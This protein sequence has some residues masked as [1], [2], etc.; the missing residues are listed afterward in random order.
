M[1]A[2]RPFALR[3]C[4]CSRGVTE[5]AVLAVGITTLHIKVKASSAVTQE[6]ERLQL[7]CWVLGSLST[8]PLSLDVS[9]LLKMDAYHCLL[10][11]QILP[12]LTRRLT[13]LTARVYTSALPSVLT[14]TS[15]T[16]LHL[17]ADFGQAA[18]PPPAWQLPGLVSLRL[19]LSK[20]SLD[21]LLGAGTAPHLTT[22]RVDDCSFGGRTLDGL[23]R[24]PSL[25]SLTLK[26]CGLRQLP[27]L[28]N[29]SNL[30]SLDVSSNEDLLD[31]QPALQG[32]RALVTLSAEWVPL[33]DAFLASVTAVPTCRRVEVTYTTPLSYFFV[34]HLY[35]TMTE[36]EGEV[37]CT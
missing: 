15:L 19:S 5:G 13:D 9:G 27:S 4:N 17:A 16:Y 20:G 12:S 10:Q 34:S 35:E 22:I 31:L 37:H 14:L 36:R 3:P 8:L 11:P 24:F 32:V 6:T 18:D 21:N 7:S 26:S 33:N 25:R 2:L 29:L 23:T 1:C 30:Q 28:A